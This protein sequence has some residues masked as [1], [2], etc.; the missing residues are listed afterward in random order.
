MATVTKASGVTAGG[1]IR[2]PGDPAADHDGSPV[3]QGKPRMVRVVKR[4]RM[5]VPVDK[6]SKQRMTLGSSDLPSTA[7]SMTSAPS[8]Y[9]A[10]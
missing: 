2:G 7:G 10:K 1:L 8:G 5:F 4:N 3:H 6:D 9:S